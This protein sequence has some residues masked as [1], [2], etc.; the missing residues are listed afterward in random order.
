M[1][2]MLDTHIHTLCSRYRS[3][4]IGNNDLFCGMYSTV[5][6]MAEEYWEERGKKEKKTHKFKEQHLISDKGGLKFL[7]AFW[8]VFAF[9]MRHSLDK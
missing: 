4:G 8:P 6:N 2:Q 7:F 3:V 5:Q 1:V 9:Y